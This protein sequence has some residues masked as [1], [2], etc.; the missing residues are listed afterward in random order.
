MIPFLESLEK[1]PVLYE[2]FVEAA[3]F[4]GQTSKMAAGFSSAEDLIR[5]TP[6]FWEKYVRPKIERDFQGLFHFL[7]N[8][9]PDGPNYYLRCVEDNIERLRRMAARSGAARGEI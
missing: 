4:A 5:K 7:A 8:P 6:G 1:L 2:E 9:L 3:R